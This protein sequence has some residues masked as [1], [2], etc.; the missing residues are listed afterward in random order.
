MTMIEVLEAGLETAIQDYPGRIGMLRHGIPPSGPLD[1]WS[2]RLANK[3]VGNPKGAAGLEC[4]F[5]GPTLRFHGE[6]VISLCGADMRPH[7]DD[8]PV[9]MWSSISVRAGQVL[10]LGP[11]IV[12]ARTYI[13]FSGGLNV[14]E[15]MGSRA[16]YVVASLGGLN[17]A[18]LRPGVRLELR[19]P[20]GRASAGEV[21]PE[22]LRPTIRN[23]K[24]HLIRVVAG[25]NDDWISRT[26]HERFC[27]A[28]WRLSGR[29]NRVGFRIEGP[30]FDYSAVA[31][32]KPREAGSDSSNTIDIGYPIGG[33]NIAGDTPII[34][35]HDCLTLGGFIVPY[36]VPSCEFWKLAQSRPWDLFRFEFIDVEEAQAE[37]RKIDAIFASG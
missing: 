2:F 21:A 9:P 1:D 14:P 12:G 17:G 32:E 29:S 13:A 23:E 28:V 31:S 25:P 15:V 6:A 4:Q 24:Q 36:T 18:A 11:A 27:S 8:S 34:L 26:G 35:L 7:L 19:P 5:L 33:I 10:S 37:R 22:A 30:K 20:T 3:V 16:T